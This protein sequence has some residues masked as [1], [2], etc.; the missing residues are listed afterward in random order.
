MNPLLPAARF[1][2][3]HCHPHPPP[4]PKLVSFASLVERLDPW[5][6]VEEPEEAPP[7]ETQRSLI[8]RSQATALTLGNKDI[9]L[10]PTECR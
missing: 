3:L 8:R 4:L 10:L 2:R 9:L 5:R 7:R 6:G 1:D